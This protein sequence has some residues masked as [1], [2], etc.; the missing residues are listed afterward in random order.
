MEHQ[1]PQTK[2][3]QEPTATGKN[4]TQ[5][6]TAGVEDEEPVSP[7]PLQRFRALLDSAR[8]TQNPVASR[9]ELGRDKSKSLFVLVG[10]SVALL[11]LFFGLFSS[12]KNRGSTA[13]RDRARRPQPRT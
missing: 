5:P 2:Q 3:I 6:T 10:A 7:N 11:L 12:P 1:G 9:R 13:G 4:Q 8:R